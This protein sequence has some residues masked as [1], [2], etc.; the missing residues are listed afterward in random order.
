M[1]QLF[2]V[3]SASWHSSTW[4]T[5]L[6]KFVKVLS[7]A[8]EC[9][10]RWS[11]E[12]ALL[13]GIVSWQHQSVKKAK[14]SCSSSVCHGCRVEGASLYSSAWHKSCTTEHWLK[15]HPWLSLQKAGLCLRRSLD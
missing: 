5:Q 3:V 2:V 14:R 6:L 10:S 12:V 9:N 1:V 13:W 11:D 15:R 7:L 4:H 8:A